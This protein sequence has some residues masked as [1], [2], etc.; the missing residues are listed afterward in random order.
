M[1]GMCRYPETPMAG[2]PKQF[3]MY[4]DE[5]GEWRWTLYAQNAKKIADSAEGYKN[6][7]DC[8]HGARLVAQVASD[9]AIWDGANQQWVT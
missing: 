9:A 6:R 3:V 7:Q 1:R 5:G 8:V 4:K 2:E